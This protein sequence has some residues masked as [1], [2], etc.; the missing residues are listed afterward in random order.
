MPREE[1][2]R[3]TKKNKKR[4]K[5]ETNKE[6]AANCQTVTEKHKKHTLSQKAQMFLEC[7][8]LFGK[9]LGSGTRK[10]RSGSEEKSGHTKSSKS[11]PWDDLPRSISVF[12]CL[13]CLC[14]YNPI[15]ETTT[16]HQVIEPVERCT[17]Q[18]HHRRQVCRPAL[19]RPRVV[20]VAIINHRKH[21]VFRTSPFLPVFYFF[22]LFLVAFFPK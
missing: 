16:C 7:F 10:I 1:T 14:P 15:P 21:A 5:H 11:E 13:L 18:L 19:T 22:F 2:T 20:A 3:K 17:E 8:G 6:N 12:F 4:G 9:F